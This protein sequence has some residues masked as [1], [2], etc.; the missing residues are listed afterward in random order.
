MTGMSIAIHP[1]TSWKTSPPSPGNDKLQK[2]EVEMET[3]IQATLAKA[4]AARRAA[5]F[6]LTIVPVTVGFVVLAFAVVG[7]LGGMPFT[8]VLMPLSDFFILVSLLQNDKTGI[9]MVFRFVNF[10][11]SLIFILYEFE[12]LAAP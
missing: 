4:R 9:K 12:E 10:I 1:S 2:T 7:F 6:Q 5:R 3:S 11:R 8:G